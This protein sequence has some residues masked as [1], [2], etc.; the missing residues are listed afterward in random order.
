MADQAL[1]MDVPKLSGDWKRHAADAAPDETKFLQGPAPRKREFWQAVRMFRELIYGFRKLHFV[2]PCVTVFGSARFDESHRYYKMA[3]EVG[4]LLAKSGFTV[5]TGG[6]PGIMEAANRGAKDVPGGRSVGCNIVLP[7]E[8]K[9][10]PY[11]DSW[12]D[13]EYFFIRK[14]MLVKYSYAFIVMPGGFGTMDELFEVATLIQTG[15]VENFPVALMGKDFWRPLVDQLRLMV[16]EKTINPIDL[17]QFIV[18]D[19]PG[20]VVSGVTDA[21]M[22]KFGLTYGPEIKPRWWFGE[23]FGRWW[24]GLM[25]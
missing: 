2:G 7:M 5:M 10:N 9:P 12:I 21:A 23:Q 15:K 20:E 24:K 8:Q 11:V 3:R 1:D 4:R 16:N 18:S 13:F 22:T 6:G 25:R 17:D 19:D 14:V